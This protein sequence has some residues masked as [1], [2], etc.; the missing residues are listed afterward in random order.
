VLT[1]GYN[2]SAASF[3]G[4]SSVDRIQQ[5]AQTFVAELQADR[6]LEGC[7]HRPIIFICHGLGGVLLKK[8]LAYSASRRSKNVEHLNSIFISTFAI[9]FFGTPHNG[10]DKSNWL[11]P[12]SHE[13]VAT[14][15]RES[16]LLSVIEKDSET[17]QQITEEFAPLM[18]Q[19]HI[20]FFWEELESTFGEWAGFV[21]EEYSA[22]PMLDDTER[23]GIHATH[24]QMVKFFDTSSSSFRTVIEALA[25]YCRMAPPIIAVRHRRASNLIAQI[26]S[27]E[28]SELT[29]TIY[30]VH[31]ENQPIEYRRRVSKDSRNK[32]FYLP[33]VVSSIYTG[34]EAMSQ[35]VEECLFGDKTPASPHQQRR[36]V[37]YGIAGSGKTQFCCHFAQTHR[38]R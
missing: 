20:F 35:Q 19:F 7:S 11:V 27:H 30:D 2:A 12:M 34:R 22:A 8:A 1:Y 10:T 21:V 26:R 31:N 29:S 13:G 15:F 14:K 17:L 33:E 4:S 25:R 28:A 38:Q 9:M 16:E 6:S 5:Q 32:H 24:S 18:K 3:Y 36:F 23:A 37:I